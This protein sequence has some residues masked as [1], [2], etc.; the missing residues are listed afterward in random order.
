M[1]V[2]PIGLVYVH[3]NAADESLLVLADTSSKYM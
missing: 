2:F 1:G 3:N